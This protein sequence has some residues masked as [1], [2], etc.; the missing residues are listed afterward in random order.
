MYEKKIDLGTDALVPFLC[1]SVQIPTNILQEIAQ[2]MVQAAQHARSVVRSEQ[3]KKS[4]LPM[5]ASQ[6]AALSQTQARELVEYKMKKLGTNIRT[7]DR[8]T[9]IHIQAQALEHAYTQA[10]IKDGVFQED[11]I[12]EINQTTAAI[13]NL[14]GSTVATTNTPPASESTPLLMKS[15]SRRN[16]GMGNGNVPPK[17][18]AKHMPTMTQPA[19]SSLWLRKLNAGILMSVVLIL[20]V[21]YTN[22][23]LTSSTGSMKEMQYYSTTMMVGNPL[24]KDV[25][26]QNVVGS[27]DLG[28]DSPFGEVSDGREN[29]AGKEPDSLLLPPPQRSIPEHEESVQ[30][31]TLPLP[32]PQKSIPEHEESVQP[33]PL[34]AARKQNSA[35]IAVKDDDQIAHG[36]LKP[37]RQTWYHGNAL[38]APMAAAATTGYQ[39]TESKAAQHDTSSDIFEATDVLSSEIPPPAVSKTLPPYAEEYFA[40]LLFDST[41]FSF[42]FVPPPVTNKQLPNKR[43]LRRARD[44]DEHNQS[45]NHGDK[46]GRHFH[47]KRGDVSSGETLQSQWSLDLSTKLK[48]YASVGEYYVVKGGILSMLNTSS[49]TVSLD[50]ENDSENRELLGKTYSAIGALIND[51]YRAAHTPRN[52]EESDDKSSTKG[53]RILKKNNAKDSV[54]QIPFTSNYTWQM[55]WRRGMKIGALYQKLSQTIED[56]YKGISIAGN[57]QIIE[58]TSLDPAEMEEALIITDYYKNKTVAIQFFYTGRFQNGESI[59]KAVIDAGRMIED[60]YRAEYSPEEYRNE[61]MSRLPKHNPDKDFP[62]WGHNWR[63]DREHRIALDRYWRQYHSVMDSFYKEQGETLST[64]NHDYYERHFLNP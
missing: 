50:W 60:Y 62:Q 7:L 55:D 45:K 9:Q 53:R 14:G 11:D 38:F 33:E 1:A 20:V 64:K 3:A 44:H 54:E 22:S 57:P 49:A 34:P 2:E 52:K 31:E 28:A 10:L 39:Q 61:M 56:H 5:S 37:S 48:D 42:P 19:I 58:E 13:P 63:D 23:S 51:H 30:P 18:N 21:Y 29:T 24:E 12:I 15:F 6:V 47:P 27:A 8:D 40:S 4:F 16:Y 26:E 41:A 59:P 46:R 17:R 32:P 25:Q 35:T 43:F 36:T